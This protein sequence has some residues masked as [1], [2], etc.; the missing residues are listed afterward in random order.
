LT[1]SARQS[2]GV[3]LVAPPAALARPSAK[4]S[5]PS[6][7]GGATRDPDD[8]PSRARIHVVPPSLVLLGPVGESS[9]RR[10]AIEDGDKRRVRTVRQRFD[11]DSRRRSGAPAH[12]DAFDAIAH[13]WTFRFDTQS[14]TASPRGPLDRPAPTPC[15]PRLPPGRQWRRR[16]DPAAPG[17]VEYRTTRSCRRHTSRARN[18]P[19]APP[20]SLAMLW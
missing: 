5:S 12:D 17:C 14:A 15:H 4:K 2:S 8:W 19:S 16:G 18:G 1:A 6:A 20:L 9:V 11:H 10:G 13:C 7:R 3:V